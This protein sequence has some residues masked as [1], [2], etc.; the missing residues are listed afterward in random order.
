[1]GRARVVATGP[2]VAQIDSFQASLVEAGYAPSTVQAHVRLL[3]MLDARCVAGQVTAAELTEE[4]VARLL[5]SAP[6]GKSHPLLQH[7]RRTGVIVPAGITQPSPGGQLLADYADY[8]RSQRRLAPG[9]VTRRCEVIGRFL[10]EAGGQKPGWD[11]ATLGVEQ[12]HG[13]LFGHASE[14]SV[15]TTR[16]AA[17]VLRCFS[18]FLFATG[19][20][21]TNLAGVV[22]GVAGYRQCQLPRAVDAATVAALLGAC[23]PATVVGL[24]DTA[25]LTL[26]LRLGLRANEIATLRL[27]DIAWR[28]GEL[29]VTGKAGRRDRLPL[30]IDVGQA[31]VGYLQ[32][33]PASTSRVV[34]LR[35]VAPRGPL[36]RNGVVMVPRDAAKRAG[37]AVVGAHRLRHTAATGMLRGGAS[38]REVGQVLRHH[39]GQTTSLYARVDLA[40]LSQLVRPWPGAGQ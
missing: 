39:A 11:A 12:L 38:L 1:M 29:E 23:D 22:P 26:M 21:Q 13:F 35:A 33:R 10:S 37:I 6:L 5:G 30:P 19:R 2:L 20:S 14:W 24:R 32:R 28:V 17:E 8:L 3:R 31:L 9:T 16:T 40:A 18:R 25:V 36:G 27:A 7:L 34:F 15:G 4:V